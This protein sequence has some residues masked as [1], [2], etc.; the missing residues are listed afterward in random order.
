[1]FQLSSLIVLPFFSDNTRFKMGDPANTPARRQQ[2][3]DTIIIVNM[4]EI[5]TSDVQYVPQ[6]S[7]NRHTERATGIAPTSQHHPTTVASEHQQ[8]TTNAQRYAKVQPDA[9]MPARHNNSAYVDRTALAQRGTSPVEEMSLDASQITSSA[10]GYFSRENIRRVHG[11]ISATSK[12]AGHSLPTRRHVGQHDGFTT[13]PPTLPQTKLDFSE[14]EATNSMDASD[15]CYFNRKVA[16]H[17]S[18]TSVSI[19]G[20]V[21]ISNGR[22]SKKTLTGTASSNTGHCLGSYNYHVYFC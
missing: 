9:S 18:V 13:P 2:C 21:Y 6:Y 11:S 3:G 4:S 19:G 1:M 7:S 8:E 10:D 17:P 15:S 20:N 12:R 5:K 14:D 22:P 16:G